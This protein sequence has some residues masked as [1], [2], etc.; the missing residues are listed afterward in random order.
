MKAQDMFKKDTFY[1]IRAERAGV[2]IGKIAFLE[3]ETVGVNSLR[4]L[5][6]WSGALDVTMIAANGVSNPGGCKF[7]V[8]LPDTDVSII[9]NV[10]EMHQL[11]AQALT[12]L[13]SIPVWK[14]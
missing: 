9:N 13:N 2:F 5:Y 1:I 7:S 14:S 3:G 12:S 8:Q 11:S 6:R 10:V 4:R